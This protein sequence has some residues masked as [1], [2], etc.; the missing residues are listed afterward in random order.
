[1]RKILIHSPKHGNKFA[2]IDDDDYPKLSKYRWWRGGKGKKY[3]F[4]TIYNGHNKK[5]N[6]SMHRMIMDY[7]KLGIDHEDGNTFNNQK[8][9]FRIC[10][11]AENVRN[12][13]R[14]IKNKSGFKGVYFDKK[15]KKFRA[16]IHINNKGKHLGCFNNANDAAIRYNQ[17]A[18]YHWGEF[19]KLNKVRDYQ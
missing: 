12:S 18:K 11:Q 7:P 14:N 13:K 1:M 19:A 4:T 8:S 15:S 5:N 2:S 16:L 6:M 10:T 3:A 17:I 9:N